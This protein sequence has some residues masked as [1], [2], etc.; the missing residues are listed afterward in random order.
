MLV[1]QHVVQVTTLKVV[2]DLFLSL[3]KGKIYVL[4]LLTFLQHL[5]HNLPTSITIENAQIPFKKSVKNVGFTLDCDL[6]MNAHATNIARTSYFEL[7]HLASIQ[8]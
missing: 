1:N 6:T 4:A 8:S 5:T 2:L 3:S 7:R